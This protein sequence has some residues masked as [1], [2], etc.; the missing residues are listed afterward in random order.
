[1]PEEGQ[2]RL[3]RSAAHPDHRLV[4]LD[5]YRGQASCEPQSVAQVGR[6]LGVS[7]AE[8]RRLYDAAADEVAYAVEH[9]A[10]SADNLPAGFRKSLM[11][12]GR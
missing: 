10:Q 4:C 5:S 9:Y 1:M 12:P 7:Q 11:S 3:A 2:S 6:Q 8:V